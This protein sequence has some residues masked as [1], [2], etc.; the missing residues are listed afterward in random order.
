MEVELFVYGTPYGEDFW[1]KDEDKGYFGNLYDGSSDEQKFLIQIRLLKGKPYCYY[2]YMVY[3]NVVGNDGRDGAYFGIS[4]R[5]DAYCKDITNLYRILDTVYNIYVLGNLLKADRSKLKYTISKFADASGVLKNIE[6]ET[7]QLVQNAFSKESFLSLNGFSAG[8]GNV[9]VYNLYDCTADKIL[10]AV[11]KFGKV[12]ISPYYPNE[13]E[14][15]QLKKFNEQIQA[16]KT[17]CDKRLQADANVHANEKKE[18]GTKLSSAT[19]KI[20]NLENDI[21]QKDSKIGEL[22]TEIDRL[23]SKIDNIKQMKTITSIIDP[24]REP[25]TKLA[26]AFQNIT[27]ETDKSRHDAAVNKTGKSE[28]KSTIKLIKGLLPFIN[29]ILL[30]LITSALYFPSKEHEAKIDVRGIY[31]IIDS[32][33]NNNHEQ[34]D[35][36]NNVEA[37]RT[38]K[39][40]NN[41]FDKENFNIDNV[42][43]DIKDYKGGP[44][45]LYQKYH[46]EAIGGIDGANWKGDGCRIEM[47]E[48]ANKVTI[49]P[50]GKTV[51]ITYSIGNKEK[52]RNLIAQ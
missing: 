44:L 12:A 13:K 7:L 31:D 11:K 28:K 37:K 34:N 49:I 23:K 4:L 51:K 9:P 8:T 19:A 33:Y 14:S 20:G 47:A 18:M 6:N 32:L 2:N 16:T 38:V 40:A 48:T 50:T 46:V 1:G 3:K 15:I 36:V 42:R 30:I 21:S 24:I 35:T 41:A 22:E 10:S 5:F 52:T 26:E 43:I 25:I 29:F 17:Q 27:P 39:Q 45:S